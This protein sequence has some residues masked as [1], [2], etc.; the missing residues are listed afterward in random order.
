MQIHVDV[1]D[2]DSDMTD[3]QHD[4]A[5]I[6]FDSKLTSLFKFVVQTK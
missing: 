5:P 2:I 4:S 1:S 3:A 6:A